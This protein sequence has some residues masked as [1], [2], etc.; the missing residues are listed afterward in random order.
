[1]RPAQFGE[2]ANSN[3]GFPVEKS[4]SIRFT[5]G[6]P[7][8][9]TISSRGPDK[10]RI[11][12]LNWLRRTETTTGPPSWCSRPWEAKRLHASEASA[13]FTAQIQIAVK[14][15]EFDLAEQTLA[16]LIQIAGDDDPKIP[17]LRRIIDAARRR[18]GLSQLISWK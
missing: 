3:L 10:M 1:V 6:G 13:L 7:E 2:T 14:R 8:R 9:W 4:A 16:S 17:Q 11:D 18:T 5:I 12:A 15:R